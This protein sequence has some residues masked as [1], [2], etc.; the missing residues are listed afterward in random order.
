MKIIAD[1]A[2]AADVLLNPTPIEGGRYVR[3]RTVT[4]DILPKKGWQVD[5]WAGPVYDEVGVS[6]KIG[7]NSSHTVIVRLVRI[8]AVPP[9]AAPSTPAPS[10]AVPPTAVPPTPTPE[11]TPTPAPTLTPVPTAPT[12]TNDLPALLPTL[13]DIAPG[14]IIG[15]EGYVEDTD[16]L[17]TYER[18]FEAEELFFN[19]GLSQLSNLSSTVEMYATSSDASAPVLVMRAMDPQLFAQ[20]AGPAFAEGAGFSPENV[21]VAAIDLPAI[22]DAT[23][24]FLMRVQTP[25]INLDVYMLWFAQSWIAAQLI[26]GGPRG[27]VHLDDIARIA[28]LIDQRIIERIDDNPPSTT[29]STPTSTPTPSATRVPTLTPVIFSTPAPTPTT[30]PTPTLAP[31]AT[32]TPTPRQAPTQVPTPTATPTP[33]PPTPIPPTPTPVPPTPTPVPPT[34]TPVPPTPTP[35]PPSPGLM[36]W[37]PGNGNANDIVS[38]VNGTMRNGATFASGKVNQAFSLDGAN[39]YVAVSNTS[40]LQIST[41]TL[42][43]WIRTT[44][45]G[46]DFRGIVVK[47]G[48]YGLFLQNGVLVTHDWGSGQTRST[49]VNLADGQFHHVAMT[50]Q[51]G[52]NGGTIIY[53]DG[54]PVLT[55]T[56]T[57][58]NQVQALV[59]GAGDPGTIQ[60]FDGIIDEAKLYNRALSGGEIQASFSGTN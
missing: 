50:F 8:I 1:P 36:N 16:A 19:L 9:T 32:A 11:T 40:S 54:A 17:V 55:T 34:P 22:G 24:G 35:V 4:I 30:A 31:A 56:M 48:A 41:G 21:V 42:E 15:E 57:V 46:G 44:N 6:A 27:Q 20:L 29:L 58:L 13:A 23:A 59:I 25:A 47:R 49:G 12:D 14:A 53:A 39:D 60:F 33:V 45:S 26:A 7:M 28:R 3:G 37:W 18:E 5:R 38:G 10:A 43:A 51:S 2:D 52:V